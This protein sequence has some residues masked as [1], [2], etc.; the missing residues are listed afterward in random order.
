MTFLFIINGREDK[1]FIK[2]EILLQLESLKNAP[3]REFYIT[4]CEGD[5]SEYVRTHALANP[6]EEFCYVAC[7]GDGTISEVAAG[8]AKAQAE[9]PEVK[10]KYLATLAYGSGNDFV[11]YYPGRDFKSVEKLFKAKPGQIDIMKVNDRYSINVTNFGFDSIVG[12]VGGVM[13][14]K[15]AKNPYRL[16]IV[17]AILIGRFNHIKVEADGELLGSRML[18]CTLANNHYVGGEF[19]CAPRAKNDDGLADVCFIRTMS[20]VKFLQILPVYTAGKHFEDKRFEKR[21][22]YRQA[23]SVKV[24]SRK[25]IYLCLDGEMLAGN[26]FN[27]EV[28]PNHINFLIP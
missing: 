3:T 14:A 21:I 28:L 23:K 22:V 12:H 1:A 11:K 4:R 20:L 5:A 10:G 15:G 17:A 16:G 6:G 24:S 19:F 2:D 7:G 18:L 25:S 8:I 13:A 9:N 26:C 27:I